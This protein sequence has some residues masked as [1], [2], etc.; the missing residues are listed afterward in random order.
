MS[1]S[2]DSVQCATV[3]SKSMVE[4]VDKL[5]KNNLRTRSSQIA[6]IIQEYFSMREEE[7]TKRER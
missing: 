1:I 7:R 6:Y 4:A 5:A 3:L 2:K